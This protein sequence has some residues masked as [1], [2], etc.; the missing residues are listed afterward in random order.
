MSDLYF[1]VNTASY[2]DFEQSIRHIPL[3]TAEE[4][5]ELFCRYQ[6][7]G[8]DDICRKIIMSNLRFVV[9][10]AKGYGGYG[11]P[12]NELVQEG[13]VGLLQAIDRFDVSH[14]VRFTT[15]AVTW[16]KSAI[17]GFAIKNY[18]I[19]KVA[20]TKTHRKLF[21]N[22]K[23]AK[24]HLGAFTHTEAITFADNMNVDVKDVLDM[25]SRLMTS[26]PAFDVVRSAGEDEEDSPLVPSEYLSG[27]DNPADLVMNSAIGDGVMEAMSNLDDRMR[28]IVTS[29]WLSAE[30]SNLQEL[31][32]KYGVSAERIR[33]IEANAFK[34]LK[35]TLAPLM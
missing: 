29:R 4:E 20:T 13:C 6:E 10:I 1:P 11:V 33:Q 16:I 25:E 21:F 12:H 31:G 34:K 30:K 35:L 32:E 5:I 28:D 8:D 9:Y 14:N 2:E 3:L 15:F 23:S 19:M 7:S 22:L 24:N 18:K 27:D 26:N 17:L